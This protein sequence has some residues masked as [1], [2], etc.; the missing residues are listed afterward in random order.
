MIPKQ[1]IDEFKT[2]VSYITQEEVIEFKKLCKLCLNRDLSLE[3][4][5][6]QGTRL[7]M[8][9]EALQ[10]FEPIP[11]SGKDVVDSMCKKKKN[12]SR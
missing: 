6:D 9:F 11:L 4:A 3:E 5:E 2:S 10:K 8:L 7:I 1:A 12:D